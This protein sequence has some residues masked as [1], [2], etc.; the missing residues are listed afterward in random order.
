MQSGF[1]GIFD[2]G[3]GGLAVYR[4]A[5]ALLP[6]QAMLNQYLAPAVSMASDVIVLGCTH[7]TFLAD[8][9][10]AAHNKQANQLL[11]EQYYLLQGAALNRSKSIGDTI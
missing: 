10:T 11:P 3:V 4:A 6:H 5:R 2:S 9:K 1:V 8:Q 7:F